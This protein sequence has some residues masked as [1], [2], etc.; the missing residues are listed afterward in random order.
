VSVGD[1]F[2]IV[3]KD[4]L[5]FITMG[6][7]GDVFDDTRQRQVS[8]QMAAYI[9][10]IPVDFLV[11]VGDNFYE[12]GVDSDHD[13]QWKLSYLDIYNATAFSLPW[14]VI[15]GNHDWYNTVG[16]QAQVDYYLHK[17][18]NRWN[19]PA[20]WYTNTWPV[21][22]QTLQIVFYDA[23]S[24]CETCTIKNIEEARSKGELKPEVLAAYNTHK[25]RLAV[26]GATQWEWLNTT[27]ATSTADWLI[28]VGHFPVFS[29]GEHGDQ[30]ELIER[31]KPL[32][33]Q[34]NVDAYLCGH[35]HNLQHLQSESVNY[36]LSGGGSKLGTYEKTDEAVWGV[37]QDGFFSHTI[38]AATNTMATAV[39]DLNGAVIYQYT[40][41]KRPKMH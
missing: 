37:V 30:A 12:M 24:L 18:D 29:G 17:K 33:D 3:N 16:P 9:P 5:T 31:L 6:D 21:G 20:L 13:P 25:D 23:E 4:S 35:D 32:L 15:A 19:F 10:T 39:I 28:V 14:W 27:L 34:Y 41:Q 1:N 22:N 7:W 11:S 26:L 2:E 38:S 40:Q 8:D 36:F